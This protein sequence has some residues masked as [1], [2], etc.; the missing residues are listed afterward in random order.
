MQLIVNYILGRLF[1]LFP[2]H[3]T[4]SLMDM[5]A[6]FFVPVNCHYVTKGLRAIEGGKREPALYQWLNNLDDS[7]VLFTRD[8]DSAFDGG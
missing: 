3:R 2:K 7:A 5:T 8:Q 4:I 1:R 6:R